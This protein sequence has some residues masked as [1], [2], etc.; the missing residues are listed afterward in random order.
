MAKRVTDWFS[1][2]WYWKFTR[3]ETAVHVVTEEENLTKA[4]G[5]Y[6]P[7][8][9][10]VQRV[11]IWE[12]PVISVLCILFINILFWLAVNFECRFYGFVFWILLLGFLYDMWIDRIWPEISVPIEGR[13]QNTDDCTT[14]HPSILSVPEM[15]HYISETHM[16]LKNYYSWLK[17]IRSEQP[18]MFCCGMSCCFVILT[19]IGRAIP[20]S[21]IAY[22][23]VMM[24]MI[25]PGVCIHV[26]PPTVKERMRNIKTFFKMKSKDTDSEVEDY[27][28]EQTGE[29]LA[30]LQLAGEPVDDD[31]EE[32][33]EPSLNGTEDFAFDTETGDSSNTHTSFTTGVGVMPSHDEG[34]TDGL[35]VSEFDLATSAQSPTQKSEPQYSKKALDPDISDTDDED[36]AG[37][38]FQSSHFNGDSS[39]EDEKAFTQGLTFSEV[40]QSSSKTKEPVA[41]PQG[42][43]EMLTA[44]VVQ[45]VSKNISNLGAMGH[46]LL[47]TVI[48]SGTKKQEER[49]SSE[50]SEEDFEMISQDELS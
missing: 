14:V 17:N 30:L 34:S 13:R 16:C 45:A 48:S 23:I 35:D 24:V 19:L 22:I 49:T 1:R 4:L 5:R 46:S 7:Y 12:K 6:E 38:H 26:L 33:L 27:L 41:S 10:K 50:D 11:L 20:G 40:G 31:K 8:I 29:N 47:S 9:I 42:I 28:P 43:G 36:I 32:D 25:G 2:V 3:N 21:V 39:D 37:I 18:G 15:S 44:S